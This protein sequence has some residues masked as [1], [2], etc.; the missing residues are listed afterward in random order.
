[1]ARLRAEVAL[2]FEADDMRAV[3]RRLRE[4]NTAAEAAGFDF[5]AAK[6]EQ[7]SEPDTLRVLSE[8]PGA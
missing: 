6:A 2:Y 3:P 4:L 8:S 1:M 5:R 7:G